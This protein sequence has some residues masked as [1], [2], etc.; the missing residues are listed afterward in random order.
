MVVI[1]RGSVCRVRRS[2]LPPLLLLSAIR[3]S[4]YMFIKVGV[5]DFAPAAIVELRLRLAAVVPVSFLPSAGEPITGAKVGG[6][7]LILVG[8]TLASGLVV[9]SR[10]PLAAV[11]K[12]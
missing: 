7:G 5:R 8:V 1:A 4:S 3:G 2:Y 12:P 10:R 9:W 11:P 6:L